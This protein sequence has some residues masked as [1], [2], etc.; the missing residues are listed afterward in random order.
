VSAYLVMPEEIAGDVATLGGEEHR[1]LTTSARAR[2]GEAIRLTDG[3]GTLYE[4]T[5]ES[6]TARETRVRITGRVFR[7]RESPA[8]ITL[9]LALLKGKRFEW[10]L[11]K[12][13]ELG[14]S[15]VRP[16]ASERS[17]P[18]RQAEPAARWE[19]VLR[20]A[21]KQCERAW[22]PV[23]HPLADLPAVL[24]DAGAFDV[25]LL[26]E[27]RLRETQWDTA[28]PAGAREVLLLVGPEG[29]FSP[30]EIAAAVAAGF[31]PVG[32]GP[33]ILRGE[34]AAVAAVAVVQHRLGDLR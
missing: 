7:E 17:V 15:A 32:L 28:L 1:H 11:Q 2:V 3:R 31:V 14:V 30:P 26:F 23:L 20:A 5:I 9:A 21:T 6:A 27:E 19:A 33:R 22:L 18:R 29:G 25:R 34:T 24:G 8:A 10:A 4:G 16:F 12:A 13:T